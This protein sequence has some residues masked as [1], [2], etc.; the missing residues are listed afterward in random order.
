[1]MRA[2]PPKPRARSLQTRRRRCTALA[3]LALLAAIAS[4]CGREELARPNLVLI[5]IDALRPDRLAC[6]GGAAGVGTALCAL[7]DAGVR[8]AWAFSAA[9]STPPSIASLL[10][11]RLP[12]DHGVAEVATS[13][14]A[15]EA[16]TLAEALAAGGYATAA[17]V[18]NPVLARGRGFEQGFA[19]YDDQ[20]RQRERNR[21]LFER[22][23]RE[24]T[25]AALAWVRVARSPWFLWIHYQDPHGPYEPPDAGVARDAGTAQDGSALPVLADQ[26]GWRGIPAYQVLDEARAPATYEARYADEIRYLDGQLARL[27]AG[28]DA[29]EGRPA[30]LVTADHGEAFGEDEF[31]FAHGHSLAI[32]QIRI[33]LF[34]RPSEPEPGR[35]VA[36]PVSNLDV[37]PTLL[38]AAGLPR[39]ASFDGIPLAAREVGSDV[40]PIFAE[41]RLRVAAVVGKHYYARDR[42]PLA[43]PEPE[44]VTGGLVPPLPPRTA[45]LAADGRFAGY[46]PIAAD[47]APA[48]EALVAAFLA[49]PAASGAASQRVLDEPTHEALRALGYLE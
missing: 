6:Y 3:A 26:S 15:D 40:A 17:F 36:T 22:E 10:T 14:L 19:V 29:R 23:A 25:D 4:G 28:L 39:P 31:W 32:D 33:P 13:R 27:F 7:G 18:A 9:P 5:S 41:H 20:M 43:A 21:P 34:W 47:A 11:S 35:V 44:P 49:Q 45:A 2:M 12:R 16:V 46:T 30:I 24:V 8:Y 1:M 38:A 37:A 48:L 42:R